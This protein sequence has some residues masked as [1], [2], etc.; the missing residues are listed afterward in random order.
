MCPWT[1]PMQKNISKDLQRSKSTSIAV[2]LITI[3]ATDRRENVAALTNCVWMRIASSCC[4]C[5]TERRWIRFST[6]SGACSGCI[7]PHRAE[8]HTNTSKASMT[9]AHVNES[10][11][12]IVRLQILRTHLC[13]YVSTV[14]RLY[15]MH[16]KYRFL[17]IAHE[18][19]DFGTQSMRW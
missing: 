17:D 9:V 18:T 7:M 3:R 1:Q 5:R 2:I 11:L 12:K 10:G 15:F 8:A 16:M 4:Y 6:D 19:W 14:K 13:A